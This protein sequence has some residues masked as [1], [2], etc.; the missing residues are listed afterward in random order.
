MRLEVERSKLAMPTPLETVAQQ[1]EELLIAAERRREELLRASEAEAERKARRDHR[2]R[3][4]SGRGSA[5]AKPSS[6]RRRSSLPPAEERAQL[7]QALA[8]ERSV[9]ENTRAR[10]SAFLNAMLAEVEAAAP[11]TREGQANVRDLDEV[12]AERKSAAAETARG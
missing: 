12:R 1:S 7:V 10:L 11:E 3:P 6:R 9:Q 2:R 8:R 5:R 4:S